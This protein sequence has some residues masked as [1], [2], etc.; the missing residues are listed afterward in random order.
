M[1]ILQPVHTHD[2]EQPHQ[3]SGGVAGRHLPRCVGP[4]VQHA[5]SGG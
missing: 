4:S 3:D 2:G 5:P 1:R